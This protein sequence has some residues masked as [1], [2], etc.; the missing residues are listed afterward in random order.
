MLRL[1]LIF[2][3][4]CGFLTAV[5][6]LSVEHRLEGLWAQELWLTGFRALAQELWHGGLVHQRHVESSSVRDQIRV[7]CTGR[8]IL[9]HCATREVLGQSL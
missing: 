5:T 9:I 4:M 1:S 3:A 8:W 2:I 7:P 6:S